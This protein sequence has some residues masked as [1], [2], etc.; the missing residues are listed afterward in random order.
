MNERATAAGIVGIIGGG[1]NRAINNR[2]NARNILDAARIQGE[3]G[4]VR[5][6]IDNQYAA[7]AQQREHET[8][9]ANT[10]A[11]N[12][13]R[14]EELGLTQPHQRAMKELEQAHELE[15]IKIESQLRTA[16]GSA[17]AADEMRI[18]VIKGQE[19]RKTTVHAVVQE[20][21][22]L[23]NLKD[24]GVSLDTIS[25]LGTK[26]GS[27]DLRFRTRA[28]E[29]ASPQD[30]SEA[31]APTPGTGAKSRGATLNEHFGADTGI[32]PAGSAKPKVD[33]TAAAP[34]VA[35]TAPVSVAPVIEPTIDSEPAKPVSTPAKPVAPTPATGR[36]GS[37]TAKKPPTIDSASSEGTTVHYTGSGFSS[38]WKSCQFCGGSSRDE[39][40]FKT[41]HK[42]MSN[43]WCKSAVDKHNSIH[44]IKANVEG[45]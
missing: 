13:A 26:S 19:D 27:S 32:T 21:N 35:T 30:F 14:L 29:A 39:E 3:Y 6:H 9:L 42:I 36:R 18:T 45:I 28:P 33:A 43:G 12:E 22:R 24:L 4:I 23:K 16:E 40:E 8:L 11:N 1:I 41:N 44:P 2:Q 15:K 31:P 17:K 7:E 34:A 25:E 10:R 5:S 37:R 38:S 20:K